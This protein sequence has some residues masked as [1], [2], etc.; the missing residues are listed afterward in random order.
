MHMHAVL[1]CYYRKAYALLY[2]CFSC[3]CV[4][5]F[6]LQSKLF[7]AYF[8][9]HAVCISAMLITL[10]GL[11]PG[12]LTGSTGYWLGGSLVSTLLNLF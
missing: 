10:R 8:F 1:S 11:R 2:C 9:L 4:T 12:A 3:S 5:V 6:N 7:P